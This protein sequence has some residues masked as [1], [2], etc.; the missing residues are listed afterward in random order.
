MVAL[1]TVGL[2]SGCSE[3]SHEGAAQAP[4]V[5]GSSVVFPD[6]SPQLA[7]FASAPAEPTKPITHTLTGRLVWDEE[8]TVRVFSPFAG[9]VQAIR[10]K[11]GD[12]VTAGQTLA[13]IASPDFGQTQA[14]ASRAAADFAI[15][16]K[17]LDRLRDLT[18]NGVAAEKDLHAAEADFERARGELERVKARK[19]LYGG[20]DSV[21]QLYPLRASVAGVVVEKNINPGQ[22]VRPDQ[23]TSNGP[24]LFVITDPA[25]LWVQLDATERDLR[26]LRPGISVTLRTPAYPD[27][28]FAGRIDAVSDYV[29]PNTRMIKV[30][31]SVANGE[32]A[33][34]GEMFVTGEITDASGS[35]VLVPAQA[36]FLVGDRHFVFVEDGKGRYT[37]TEVSRAGEV[38]GHVAVRSG[39]QPG[40]RVVTAGTLL[41]EQVLDTE[42]GG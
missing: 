33:L 35:G 19:R 42:G 17:N 22:E 40:Q 20:G 30:R 32:R 9:S 24:P 28:T 21:D 15:A 38:G 11:V 18:A 1:L 25:R 6:G 41:L 36:V 16:Q 23:I 31:A 7:A 5:K 12:R 13:S 2:T 3:K 10:V 14:E 39:L 27:R 8:H 4:A 26:F 34:K 37:R 29:D